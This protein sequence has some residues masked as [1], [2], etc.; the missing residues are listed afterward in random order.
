MIRVTT[1]FL[2]ILLSTVVLL[3]QT[4]DEARKDIYH[5]KYKTAKEKLN[6]ILAANGKDPQAI[7]WL[8][9]ATIEDED[10]IAGAKTVYQNNCFENSIFFAK[11]IKIFFRLKIDE[12]KI[13]DCWY[14]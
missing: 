8:G 3:A 6:K 14:N 11:I 5:G 12:V 13:G 4:V 10:N 7:Y 1:F 2:A 9:Q